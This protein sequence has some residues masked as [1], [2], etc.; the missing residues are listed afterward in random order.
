[1]NRFLA[2]LAALLLAAPVLAKGDVKAASAPLAPPTLSVING[3]PLTINVASDNSY[4][5]FNSNVG[6][7]GQIY[8]SSQTTTA[9]MGW[10]VDINGTL[11]APNFGEHGGTATGGLGTY[12]PFGEISM[13]PVSGTGTP[14][15]PYTVTVSVNLGDSGFRATKTTTYI[16]GNG[17][18]TERFRVVNIGGNTAQVSIF[19]G[20]DIYLASSDSGRPFLEPTSSSPGGRTCAG[21]TPEYTILHIPLTPARR[22]TGDR[23][24]PPCGRRSETACWTAPSI[25][26]PASTTA[27]PC[28][29]RRRSR[30]WAAFTVLAATSFGEVPD[31]TQFNI[32]DVNPSQGVIG[33]TLQVTISGYGFQPTTTFNFGAGISVSG[34]QIL[35]A[36]SALA[37][38]EIAADAMLGFR[39]VIA[40][41]QPGGLVATL[42]D[43]FAVSEP[44]I[45]N[46]G[47]NGLNTVNPQ[48][49]ACVRSKFPFDPTSN[50]EGWAPSEGEWFTANPVNPNIPLP[51]TG[52]ARAILD[53]YL[54]PQVWNAQLGYLH[55][56]FCWLDPAPWYQGG[57]PDAR[58]AQ[59]K[60][61]DAVNSVCLGPQP[62]WP[63]Y[64]S[65]V[66]MT[67]I[68]FF[69]LALPRNGFEEP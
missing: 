32:T 45:W 66:S 42:V 41:Q 68:L 26:A 16:N 10:F 52:L 8:P 69:P 54:N 24:T 55:D 44:P 51:P 17:Y 35:N 36:N 65:E 22:Y 6:S 23:S 48:A 33:T 58:V 21:V 67:R 62:G 40:T 39:D 63:I 29:G 37:T 28:S 11:Y 3:N 49:V 19:L 34:V 31:I 1:M 15:S 20:S 53:C 46:Y 60:L 43:G 5:I 59:L 61:Y 27:R 4:Q 2:F 25:R 47:I 9:D 30:R 12:I 7:A 56:R 14:A 64:E 38:L 18:F 50:A 13:T 57:Y